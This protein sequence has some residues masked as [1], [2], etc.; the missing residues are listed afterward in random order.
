MGTGRVMSETTMHALRLPFAISSS[1][2]VA[3]GFSRLSRSRAAGLP[4]AGISRVRKTVADSSNSTSRPV[5]PYLRF[6]FISY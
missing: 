5:R 4:M 2:A 1:G 3:I 6:S